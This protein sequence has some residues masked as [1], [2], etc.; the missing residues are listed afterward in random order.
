MAIVIGREVLPL[1]E[2]VFDPEVLDDY[3][4]ITIS[5]AVP[6]PGYPSMVITDVSY[7]TSV[8]AGNSFDVT[9]YWR[10]DGEDGTAWI[11]VIDLD[12]GDVLVPT[13]TWNVTAG[14]TGTK[15]VSFVMPNRDV[16]LRIEL[17]HVE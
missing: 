7:P 3:R 13:Q 9:V 14:E 17:G 2:R 8:Q 15:I 5:L 16:H 10:N 6:P 11:K 12:T 4:D 1:A